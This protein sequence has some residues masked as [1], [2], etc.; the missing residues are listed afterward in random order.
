MIIGFCMLFEPNV[1]VMAAP[2]MTASDT[3][4]AAPVMTAPVMTA[5]D[6]VLAAPVM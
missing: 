5:P 4:L 1:H 3:V 6:P 2:V